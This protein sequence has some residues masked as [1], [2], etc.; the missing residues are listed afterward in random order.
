M[1][2]FVL[3]ICVYTLT[4]DAVYMHNERK[5]KEYVLSQHGQIY[6]GTY[7]RIKGT[8]WNFGQVEIHVITLYLVR[9]IKI[10]NTLLKDKNTLMSN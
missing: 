3:N 1:L 8:P 4:G 7:K 10:T 2:E 9:F 6:K 5:R